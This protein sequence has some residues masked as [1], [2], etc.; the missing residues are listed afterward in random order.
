MPWRQIETLFRFFLP[1]HLE[2]VTSWDAPQAFV[3]ANTANMNTV[4][5]RRL[6]QA[7][8]KMLTVRKNDAYNTEALDAAA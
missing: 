2:P 8:K 6:R 1:S 4:A 3:R 7:K 5:P